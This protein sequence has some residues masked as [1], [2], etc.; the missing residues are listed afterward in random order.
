M[1]LP[2]NGRHAL[3]IIPFKTLEGCAYHVVCVGVALS[4]SSLSLNYYEVCLSYKQKQTAALEESGVSFL[5]YLL[6]NFTVALSSL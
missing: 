4:G 3:V 5:K 6:S 1:Y 2:L